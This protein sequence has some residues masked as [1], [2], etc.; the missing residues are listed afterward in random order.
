MAVVVDDMRA[1]FGRMIMC[2]MFADTVE[3]LHHMAAKIGVSQKWFQN[4]RWE[5]YDICL[6]K[7]ALAVKY[8]AQEIKY[9]ELPKWLEDR[10][11]K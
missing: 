6:S 9:R 10:G 7:R 11:R 1:R 8:G 5:H 4:E 3:E 2:H